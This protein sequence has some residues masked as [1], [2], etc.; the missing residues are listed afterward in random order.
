MAV[1]RHYPSSR[2]TPA[3]DGPSSEAPSSVWV[4]GRRLRWDAFGPVRAENE[5]ISVGGE[6]QDAE[7]VTSILNQTNNSDVFAASSA[8]AG[9][10]VHGFSVSS[11]GVLGQSFTGTGVLG[12]D[13]NGTAP[14]TVGHG[15]SNYTGV[16]G[17]SSGLEADALPSPKA[18][19][20]V[21]GV[22]NQD[23]HSVGV[24]GDS[25]AGHAIHGKTSTGYGGYFEGKV[26]TTT[27]YELTEIEHAQQPHVQPGASVHPRQRLG[28]DPALRQVRQWEREDP[29]NRGLGGSRTDVRP[30]PC[31]PASA[32]QRTRGVAAQHASLSRWRS[33]VRIRSG[34][35][36]PRIAH[37]IGPLPA[38]LDRQVAE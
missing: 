6:Y 29:G 1:Q 13:Q 15:G 11:T 26:Y 3:R 18:K 22:A 4:P 30:H 32:L 38:S 23:G 16:L 12:V 35:P 2:P 21:H 25:S 8:A 34:P 33:P 28:Q 20:G 14:A 24:R 19:T 7:S 31:Y 36:E 17:F 10:A 9:V 27:W 5:T 37:R